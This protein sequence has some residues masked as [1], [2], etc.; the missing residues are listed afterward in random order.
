M[1][2]WRSHQG[3]SR[4]KEARSDEVCADAYAGLASADRQHARF[5]LSA[6][7]GFLLADGG[8]L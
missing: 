4:R 8:V 1:T 3:S 7:T 2:K 5:R 6:V